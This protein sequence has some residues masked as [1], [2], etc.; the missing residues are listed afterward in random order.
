MVSIASLESLW[1]AA[2]SV[3]SVEVFIVPEKLVEVLT[4]CRWLWTLGLMHEKILV[5]HV[6]QY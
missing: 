2:V 1:M 6:E 5:S 3:G 4:G